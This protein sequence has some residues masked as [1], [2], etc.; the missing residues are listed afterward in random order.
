M[1]AVH[2][3]KYTNVNKN[4]IFIKLFLRNLL[5]FNKIL[6]CKIFFWSTEAGT[7]IYE[8]YMT[9]LLQRHPITF[10]CNST[11]YYSH[12]VAIGLQKC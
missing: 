7:L 1:K 10:K 12:F 11:Y 5:T 2:F 9:C 3:M 4:Y 6:L 8:E